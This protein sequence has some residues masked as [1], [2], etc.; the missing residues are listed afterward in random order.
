MSNPSFFDYAMQDQGGRRSR[1]FLSEMKAFIPW[2]ALEKMLIDKGAYR[3]REKG[4]AGRP[5]YR[6]SVLLGALFLQAWYD[7]SDPM[8]EEMIHD[9]LSFREF[10]GIQA[11][12]DIPDETTIGNFRNALMDRMLFDAIFEIVFAQMQAND[13]VLKEGTLVDATLIHSSEPKRK[14]DKKGKVIRNQANDTDATYTVKRNQRYHG[15]KIHIGTDPNGV[16]KKMTTTTAKAS[17]TK[18]FDY[19]TQDE[20]HFV[21]AD[22]AYMSKERKKDLRKKGIT[23]GIIERRVRGQSK[24]RP[25]QT[26]HNKRFAPIRGLVELSFAFIKHHMG[27][28]RTRFKGLEKNDQY[29]LLLGAAYNIRRAPALVRKLHPQREG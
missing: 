5:P 19:L 11:E 14:K 7:L 26:K 10:L 16:I 12:D 15:Y 4:R 24:L 25:K 3:P 17:D 27:Y 20:E 2:E 13:L 6:S 18:E 9:R 21:T 8:T 28:R 22:S 29:H 23:N 1:K